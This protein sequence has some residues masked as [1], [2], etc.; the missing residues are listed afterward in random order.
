MIV[1]EDN[2]ESDDDELKTMQ[3]KKNYRFGEDTQQSNSTPKFNI[4]A[5]NGAGADQALTN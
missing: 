4:L 2:E 5:Q 3:E 1:E